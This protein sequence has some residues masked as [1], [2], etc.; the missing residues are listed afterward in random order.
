[1]KVLAFVY[2]FIDFIYLCGRNREREFE[3]EGG[4]KRGG[5][6]DFPLNREPGVGLHP[7]TLGS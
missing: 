3:S 2:V 1:M 4:A 6:V 5:E 7:R